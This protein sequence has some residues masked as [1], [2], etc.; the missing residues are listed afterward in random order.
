MT[1]VDLVE[2]LIK[3]VNLKMAGLKQQMHF[4]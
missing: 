4:A 3:C 1:A 2:L